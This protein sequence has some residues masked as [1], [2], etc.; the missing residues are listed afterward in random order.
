MEWSDNTIQTKAT[1]TQKTF[2][3]KQKTNTLTGKIKL[4]TQ[5]TEEADKLAFLLK[6]CEYL[7]IGKHTAYGL[8]KYTLTYT[9]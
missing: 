8:G 1:L 5:N 6:T 3:L 4:E 7:G 9:P 2:H